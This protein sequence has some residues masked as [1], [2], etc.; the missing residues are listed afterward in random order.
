[1]STTQ[2]VLKSSPMTMTFQTTLNGRQREL[3][4]EAFY[5]GRNF[6][7]TVNLNEALE[8]LKGGKLP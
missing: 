7:G 8:A 2:K 4:F 6:R 3:P 1:M 5:K